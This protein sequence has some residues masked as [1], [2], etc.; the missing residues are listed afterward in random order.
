MG[1]HLNPL[2]LT[3][4]CRRTSKKAMVAYAKFAGQFCKCAVQGCW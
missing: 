2:S 3:A 1:T 4:E